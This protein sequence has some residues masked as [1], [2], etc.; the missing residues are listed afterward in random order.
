[1]AS[2]VMILNDDNLC[3]RGNHYHRPGALPWL[4]LLIA[5]LRSLPQ[6]SVIC[7]RSLWQPGRQVLWPGW[8]ADLSARSLDYDSLPVSFRSEAVA[9]PNAERGEFETRH[10]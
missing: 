7:F 3:F 10:S 8:V 2:G 6:R 5:I 1:M 9:F 4:S